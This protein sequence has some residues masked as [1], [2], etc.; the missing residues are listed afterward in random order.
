MLKALLVLGAAALAVWALLDLAQTPRSRVQVLA[1]PAWVLA[2][3]LLPVLGALAWFM[4]GRSATAAPRPPVRPLAPDDDPEF[5]R[6][7]DDE[8]RRE[9]HGDT[10]GPAG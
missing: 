9:Q 10:G 6:H 4:V 5:L 2:V 1:K 3:V 8:R 7:L